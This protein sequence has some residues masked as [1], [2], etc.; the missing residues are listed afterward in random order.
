M[1]R[2][3]S[4]KPPT[5]RRVSSR[6]AALAIAIVLGAMVSTH[7]RVTGSESLLVHRPATGDWVEA[8]YD[9][10]DARVRLR[11]GQWG[12]GWFA[13]PVRLDVAQAGDVFLYDPTTGRCAW[14]FRRGGTYELTSGYLGPG[15]TIL[16]ADFDRD[17][18]NDLL[19][20]DR[21]SGHWLQYI[22]SHGTFIPRDGGRWW[23]DATVVVADFSGDGRSDVLAYHPRSGDFRLLTTVEDAS[24]FEVRAGTWGDGWALTAAHL[25]GDARADLFFYRP[26]SGDWSVGLSSG[27]GSLVQQAGGQWASGWQ[28]RAADVNADGLDDILLYDPVSGRWFRCLMTHTGLGALTSGR[29]EAASE[30]AILDFDRDGRADVVRFNR[31]LNRFVLALSREVGP[32]SETAGIWPAGWMP[33]TASG[34]ADALP[35]GGPAGTDTVGHPSIPMLGTT[36]ILAFGDSITT[37]VTSLQQRHALWADRS[38]R[39]FVAGYPERLGP[40][41]APRY[42]SQQLVGRNAGVAG[43]A[44]WQGVSR[45]PLEFDTQA[46]SLV[47]ILEGVNDLINQLSP[48]GAADN[49]RQMVQIAAS[50]GARVVL[51]TLTP[52]AAGNSK[53]VPLEAVDDLNARIRTIATAEGA[54]LADLHAA[55]GADVTLISPDGVHPT[56]AGYARMADVFAEVIARH[57]EFLSAPIE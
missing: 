4:T 5:P 50:R 46:W 8:T 23:P 7:P 47:L 26:E 1:R 45:L 24:M 21:A 11:A 31:T 34:V 39:A 32:F 44:T 33:A 52:V 20:Y 56:E 55:F 27:D 29:W 10:A 19:T 38:W 49:L 40:L 57:F 36:S 41:L 18:L 6:A 22:N 12:S 2:A 53:G 43:E 15:L 14:A 25:N 30:L 9:P 28:V 16:P 35:I 3:P 17:D 13:Y 37:G 42:P 51:S 48:A 54:V